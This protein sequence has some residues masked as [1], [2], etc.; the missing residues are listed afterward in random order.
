MMLHSLLH[1]L[2][3]D[4]QNV[5]SNHFLS[6]GSCACTGVWGDNCSSVYFFLFYYIFCFHSFYF[7]LIPRSRVQLVMEW[8][9]MVSNLS[10]ENFIC[11]AKGKIS[12][13]Y[14]KQFFL[15]MCF[16]R[17][18][19]RFKSNIPHPCGPSS[20]CI[21]KAWYL[22]ICDSITRLLSYTS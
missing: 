2:S 22:L 3:R 13:T 16:L 15:R 7:W 19:P 9:M 11:Y 18:L 10:A 14:G 21:D 12:S 4:F 1:I 8:K 17:Q 5:G 20:P 6:L